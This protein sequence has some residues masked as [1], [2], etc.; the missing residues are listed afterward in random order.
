[1]LAELTQ[2]R[3]GPRPNERAKGLQRA[4]I[5]I[6][7]QIALVRR[8]STLPVQVDLHTLNFMQKVKPSDSLTS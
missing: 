6:S 5:I 8:P 1:M 4:L 2:N 7:F 3:G